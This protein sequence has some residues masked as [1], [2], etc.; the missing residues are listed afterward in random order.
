MT[1]AGEV[2]CVAGVGS[3]IE[4]FVVE[5][6]DD[7][8]EEV[9]LGLEDFGFSVRAFP[10]SRE[11]YRGLLQHRCDVVVLDVGLPGEDGFSIAR[12]LRALGVVGIVM[13]TARDGVD[14]RVRGLM[15]GADAYLSKPADLD[16]LAA[17]LVSVHRRVKAAAWRGDVAQE[18]GASTEAG[19]AM[20]EDGWSLLVPGGG[21]VAL[22]PSERILLRSLF[23][24]VNALVGRE[25]LIAALGHRA[26]YYL[27]HRLDMLISRLRAKVKAETGRVLPLRAVR[28]Q[29][30]I[31]SAAG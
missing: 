21:L 7:L 6:D 25:A 8:R 30:F 22:T 10:A 28:G 4:I 1:M 3:G 17:T 24:K 12:H 13:L 19:W 16:E 15:D 31:L 23:G 18:A 20:T 9:S 14:D 5:D 27:D 11:M 29:G 26:D 2:G